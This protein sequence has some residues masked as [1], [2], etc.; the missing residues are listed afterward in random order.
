MTKLTR[1]SL[2][3]REGARAMEIISFAI[4]LEHIGDIIDKNLSELAA[5]KIKRRLQF[6]AEGEAELA[7]FHKRI[8]DNLKIAFSVF[9]SGDVGAGAQAD[10]REVH[11]AQRRACRRRG[12]LR[13]AAR[14]A[15]GNAGDDL[16]ASRRAARPQAHPFA[17]LLGRLPGARRGW[18]AR[19]HGRRERSDHAA[20]REALDAVV[21]PQSD[22]PKPEKDVSKAPTSDP[23][24]TPKARAA[25]ARDV[26]RV[27]TI[28]MGLAKV[29]PDDD[30]AQ[31]AGAIAIFAAATIKRS[32]STLIEARAYLDG[33]RAGIDGLLQNAFPEGKNRAGEHDRDA[34][35][36][37]DA[38]LIAMLNADVQQVHADS[39]RGASSSRDRQRSRPPTRTGCW[40]GPVTAL[41]WRMSTCTG[42]LCPCRDRAASETSSHF[43]HNMIY[44]HHISV[45][46]AVRQRGVGRALMDAVKARGKAEGIALLALDAWALT[47]RRLHFPPLW[48]VPYNR[49]G[50][51]SSDP[52]LKFQADAAAFATS[53]RFLRAMVTF[54]AHCDPIS[55]PEHPT[56]RAGRY[57][58]R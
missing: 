35:T 40:P 19:R 11:A 2:D 38:A 6:S 12:P 10:R 22:G 43:A 58:S 51:G 37:N 28:A 31:V 1:E 25:A 4:N 26:A 53:P 16:A 42:G 46:P 45:R 54:A 34:A 3:D 24:K 9:M 18:S 7:A 21:G 36:V 57:H 30:P 41:S 48:A 5:K 20:R 55:R 56:G 33:L 23:P 50:R 29:A 17:Y 8:L 27:E 32:A 14:G 39:C 44:V 52:A 13:A 47:S 49:S 15:A